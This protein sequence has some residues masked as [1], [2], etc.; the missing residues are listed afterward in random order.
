MKQLAR[1]GVALAGGA[2]SLAAILVVVRVAKHEQS[3]PERCPAGLLPLS[4]RCC[5]PGQKLV[6]GRCAGAPA[7][8]PGGMHVDARRLGCVAD[9]RRVAIAEGKL[10]VGADDWQ[11]EG[12][13]QPRSTLVGAFL[14]D[15]NEVTVERWDH[16]VRAGA[17]RNIDDAEPGEPVTGVN[18]KEA[19]RFCRFDGGRLPTSDEWMFAAMGAEGR[20][21][22]WGPTGLICRR[23]SFGLENGPCATG[24]RAEIAGARP[25]GATPDGVQDL[26]G[27]VAEWTVER[28]GTYAARG[29]SY[30][31]LSALDLKSWSVA[32]THSPARWIGFRC[33]YDRA[34]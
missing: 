14:L 22:P 17:C 12:I 31:S 30:R 1:I 3:G 16:C 4:S 20:R 13:V 6:R 23:A 28:D 2:I 29:G 33:A 32:N 25:D 15:A 8:C 21:F 19:G 27:N 5:A 24:G 11:G 34:L 7:S 10:R 26:A 18:P 9:A